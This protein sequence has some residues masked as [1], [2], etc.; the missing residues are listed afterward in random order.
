MKSAEIFNHM[1]SSS[2]LRKQ[3]GIEYIH[4]VSCDNIHNLPGDVA[5]LGYASS[6][7]APICLKTFL[8]SDAGSIV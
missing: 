5:L 8:A 7:P 6:V 1:Y 2:D 3:N 4:F